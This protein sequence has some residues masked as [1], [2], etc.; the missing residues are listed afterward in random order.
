MVGYTH[1]KEVSGRVPTMNGTDANQSNANC[2]NEALH[3]LTPQLITIG[4]IAIIILALLIAVLVIIHSTIHKCMKIR[5]D[6]KKKHT[7][8]ESEIMCIQER[9]DESEGIIR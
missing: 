7:G 1:R 2:V 8:S 3:D 5:K 6:N 9:G 4:V